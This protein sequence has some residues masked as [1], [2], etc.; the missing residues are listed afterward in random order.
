MGMSIRMS[1]Y[2]TGMNQ[3]PFGNPFLPGYGFQPAGNGWNSWGISPKSGLRKDS[4]SNMLANASI[5]VGLIGGAMY[6]AYRRSE[7]RAHKREAENYWDMSPQ[8]LPRIVGTTR[9]SHLP[10]PHVHHR[11]E[12]LDHDFDFDDRRDILDSLDGRNQRA[13]DPEGTIDWSRASRRF[14]HSESNPA[15]V[16][17]A[18]HVEETLQVY[19]GIV[20]ELK[21]RGKY[22][23]RIS[24][25][26]IK[27]LHRAILLDI[28][29]WKAD[30]HQSLNRLILKKNLYQQI[31]DRLAKHPKRHTFYESKHITKES[32]RNNLKSTLTPILSALSQRAQY[33]SLFVNDDAKSTIEVEILDHSQSPHAIQSR[34]QDSLLKNTLTLREI[35]QSRQIIEHRAALA[36]FETIRILYPGLIANFKTDTTPEILAALNELTPEYALNRYRLPRS[37][38]R[39]DSFRT[40]EPWEVLFNTRKLLVDLS[41]DTGRKASDKR[42]V[43]NLLVDGLY[44][45]KEG[46]GFCRR[47]QKVQMGLAFMAA[48]RSL[49]PS[50]PVHINQSAVDLAIGGFVSDSKNHNVLHKFFHEHTGIKNRESLSLFLHS[51]FQAKGSDLPLEMIQ[52]KLARDCADDESFNT[53]AETFELPHRPGSEKHFDYHAI[54][55]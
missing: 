19:Q 18:A 22:T 40:L 42:E 7:S 23:Q 45:V 47:G 14:V 54:S 13:S 49:Q 37:I 10:T 51:T 52:H 11:Q 53:L 4:V 6:Y 8:R 33:Q 29:H 27:T 39:I 17:H 21:K 26:D 24:P 3:Q 15:S 36:G 55:K 41:N 12:L 25:D 31:A 28:E 5:G 9:N 30:A 43:L 32:A 34:N 16:E 20:A 48:Q 35:N 1:Q 44:A 38:S 50:K 2:V 46:D